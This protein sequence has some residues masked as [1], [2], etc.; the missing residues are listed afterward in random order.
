ME[1]MSHNKNV[2]D[3]GELE[4]V[5]A[6]ITYTEQGA[7][8]QEGCDHALSVTGHSTA[9]RARIQFLRCWEMVEGQIACTIITDFFVK[10]AEPVAP[11]LYHACTSR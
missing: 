1:T 9:P 10:I 6:G 3:V 7:R 2:R 8:E 4:K 11:H 5:L